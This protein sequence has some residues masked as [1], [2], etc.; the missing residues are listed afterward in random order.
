MRG[1]SAKINLPKMNIRSESLT[2]VSPKHS[3]SFALRAF[4]ASREINQTS[5]RAVRLQMVHAKAPFDC[6]AGA[7]DKLCLWRRREKE[8]KNL[9]L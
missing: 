1:V 8:Q 4:A 6:L 9:F 5:P 2:K 7:Q 3:L